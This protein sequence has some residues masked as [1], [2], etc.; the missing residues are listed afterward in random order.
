LS[1]APA[2][3]RTIFLMPPLLLGMLV[4]GFGTSLPEL[5]VCT[6]VARRGEDG[7]VL[8]N[9]LGSALGF[10][11]PNTLAV[12]G[13]AG[14]ISPMDIEPVLLSRDLPVVAGLN[15]L[16]FVLGGG[17]R[18]PGRIDR[19]E[20]GLLLLAYLACTAWLLSSLAPASA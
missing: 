2:P 16:L 6:V 10:S 3:S 5:A 9:V 12:V 15:V 1:T 4:L 20:G 17:F 11:L 7:M 13:L 18:G 14:A 8:G 19:T